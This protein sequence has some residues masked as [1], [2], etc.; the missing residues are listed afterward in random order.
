MKVL[1]TAILFLYVFVCATGQSIPAEEENIP[2]MVTFGNE[3]PKDWGDD[4]YCQIFFIIIPE[5]YS[6]SFYVRIFDPDCGGLFDEKREDFNTKTRF[7]LYGGSNCYSEPDARKPNP[8]GNYKSGNLL[9]SKIFGENN[10]Y[11][12]NWYT[13]GPLNPSE[14]EYV[15]SY[16]GHIFKIIAEGI[17]GNDGNLYKYF[18]SSAENK[19]IVVEGCNAFTYEYTFRLSDN[20]K[21]ISH[22]YPFIDKDVISIKVHNFD[23]DKD[24]YIRIISNAKNGLLCKT[25]NEGDWAS[26]IFN[27]KEEEKNSTFDIQL[28]KPDNNALK[29]N[30]GVLYI[31]NQY[32][33]TLPFY[34]TPIGGVPKYIYKIKVQRK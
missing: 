5:T 9:A 23:W 20:A 22:I 6:S 31:T 8:S 21:H 32:N 17:S 30:N 19:N 7:S 13:F 3:A 12:N 25:S 28:I 33:E 4:D 34:T 14:G 24:G 29:N 27:V 2:F 18:I 11:D 10:Q 15:K 16:K 26:S 1:L